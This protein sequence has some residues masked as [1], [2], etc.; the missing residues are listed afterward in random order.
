MFEKQIAKLLKPSTKLEE[1][2]I[3]SLLETPPDP[4][5]GDYAFPCFILAKE[6]K[7]APNMIAREIVPKIQKNTKIKEIKVI[8]PYIN[9]FINE[10]EFAEKTITKILKE[11]EKYGSSNTG[12]KQKVLIEHTS[13][14]PNSPPHL[15]RLRSAII[16]DS[17]VKILKFQ[18]YKPEVHFFVNDVGKQIAMLVFASKNKKPTFNKLLGLYIKINKQIEEK[19]ELENEIFALLNKLEKGDKKTKK[20]F[21]DVVK[22][23]INGQKK[24]L[25]ELNLNYDFFDYESDYLW[26]NS[27]TKVLKQ[28][29]KKEE[30]F[31]DSDNRYVINQEEFVNEMKA[32]YFVLTRSDG[33]SLYGLRDIAYTIDKLKKS[34]KNII[35][36]GED[37]K[38]YFK[39]LSSAL[40]L[41]N[42]T[43]PTAIHYSF[44]LLSDKSKMSTRKGNLVLLEDFMK[45]LFDK[46]SKEI[47]T[48]K[49]IKY[50]EKITKIIAY[51][52]L[53]YTILK[54]SPDKN[55]LFDWKSALSF[56]GE[57]CPYIQYAYT[58]ASSILRKQKPKQKIDFKLIKTKEEK[59]LIKHLALFPNIVKKVEEEFKPHIIANY[60]YKAAK[61]FTDFYTKCRVL[62]EDK[63]LSN[64]RLSIV[65]ITK[66]TI[67]NSLALLGIETTDRM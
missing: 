46:A 62:S 31:L 25:G 29:K 32:P 37:H 17:I 14:N 60:V 33:T 11:K 53:K 1:E 24:V 13:I 26:A 7:K 55:V 51:G 30:V 64:T 47:K 5:L 41:L 38:L 12:K 45:E 63:N 19:P 40:K 27:T 3:I 6:F 48:R 2:K 57:S 22:I 58:R 54:V 36:L 42:N 10:K 4:R 49:K 15:G 21:R 28:L 56:E 20:R 61:L 23:C 50:S 16:G 8:G 44:V 65:L 9:F 52:A 35:V 39:Q 34:K 18:N 43:S 66:Y 59:N 67:K